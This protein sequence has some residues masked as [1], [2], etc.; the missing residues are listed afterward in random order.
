MSH[1][2][3]LLLLLHLQRD[4]NVDLA[5][6]AAV[7]HALLRLRLGLSLGVGLSRR[8]GLPLH[9]VAAH[10]LR[11][12]RL[13]HL[14][15]LLHL[16]LH[17]RRHLR[18]HLAGLHVVER[19]LVLLRQLSLVHHA[20]VLLLLLHL[21]LEHLLLKQVLLRWRELASHGISVHHVV[22]LL[23]KSRCHL[24][25]LGNGNPLLLLSVGNL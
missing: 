8:Y 17:L 7:H 9:L 24:L 15:L 3:L 6:T 1:L 23:G 19:L 14:Q 2:L 20:A 18:L 25:L 5:A 21:T 11:Q 12:A 10:L 13:L 22:L 16:E 4:A